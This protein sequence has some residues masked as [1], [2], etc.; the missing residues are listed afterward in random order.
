MGAKFLIISIIS[1]FFSFGPVEYN[2]RMFLIHF[3]AILRIQTVKNLQGI[4]PV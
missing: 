1:C 4:L 3:Q 2:K